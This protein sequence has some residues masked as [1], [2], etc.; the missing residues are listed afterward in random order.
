MSSDARLY[1]VLGGSGMLGRAWLRLLERNA[2]ELYL[3]PSEE[4]CDLTDRRS[5][6]NLVTEN[7]HTVIN[8]AA[9]TDVDGA[10]TREDDAMRIN[11]EAVGDLASR[12]REVGAT[13][14]HYST[15]YVFNG[16]ATLPYRTD[17]PRDPVNAYGRSKARGE[18]LLESS[19]CEH[20][21]IRTSW[22]YAAWG[23]NFVRT[24]AR[25]TA[26]KPGLRVVHDQRGRPTSAEHLASA[27]LELLRKDLRGTYHVADA[28]QCTWYEF[29]EHI[30]S[31]LGHG[32]DIQPC[33]THQFPRPAAR[34]AYSVLDLSA[35]ETHIG[36]I[37][38]WQ[39]NLA[40][41]LP[42]LARETAQEIQ[43]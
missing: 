16:C 39:Q 31:E 14:V 24:M 11:G 41:V 8:C 18:E 17:H 3:A 19:G 33:N 10:E 30:N 26:E 32:C 15:D 35:I 2:P 22:L 36:P 9:F 23:N 40:Q 25:L 12:C 20:L 28:G 27:S 34:P 1:L 13:L 37:G 6:R 43:P 21:L 42:H 5:I 4:Q 7:V 38:T 29:A